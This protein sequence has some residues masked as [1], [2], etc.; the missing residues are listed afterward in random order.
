MFH[1]KQLEDNKTQLGSV[2]LLEKK[3]KKMNQGPAQGLPF[4]ALDPPTWTD[5]PFSAGN[6]RERRL[7]TSYGTWGK[8]QGTVTIANRKE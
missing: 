1:K 5:G 8:R 7:R 4:T 3:K 2:P 6:W